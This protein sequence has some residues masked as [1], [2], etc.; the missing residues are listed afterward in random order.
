MSGE[1]SKV[2][3]M[4]GEKR[5]TILLVEDDVIIAMA[6]AQMLER[7]GYAVL[8]AYS[9]EEAVEAALASG[10]VDLI[11]MDI[12]LGRGMDGTEAAEIILRSRNVPVVFLSSHTE[13]SVVEKTEKITS[14]GYVVKNI[15]ETVLLASIK[16]AFRLHEAKQAELKKEKDLVESESLYRALVDSMPDIVMRFDAE[17]RHLFVSKNI[18]DLVAIPSVD[19]IGKTHREKGFPENLC[20]FWEASIR[21][22][23]SENKHFEQE[24][25]VPCAE[26]ERVLNLRLV[27]EIDSDGNVSSVLSIARDIT[28]YKK[29]ES[30]YH[31][32]FREAL[33]GFAL[34]EIVLDEIGNPCDYRFLSVNPAF[35]KITGLRSADIIGKTVLEVLPG[36]EKYWIEIY[37]RVALK[38]EQTIFENYSGELGKYFKVSAYQPSPGK[39]ACLFSDITAQKQSEA[40]IRKQDEYLRLIIES[41]PIGI[42]ILD[43]DEKCLFVNKKFTSISGYTIDDM[44]SSKEWWLKA[45]PDEPYRFSIR[46]KWESAISNVLST[47]EEMEPLECRVVCKDGREVQAEISFVPVGEL[48]A[49]T[50][51]KINER[52]LS[53]IALQESVEQALK[54]ERKRLRR[55]I[56][57]ADVIIV[58]INVDRTIAL[59]NRKG[60]ETLGRS[61]DELI[62]RNWFDAAVPAGIRKE[63]EEKFS[64]LESGLNGPVDRVENEI[65]RADGSTRTISWHNTVVRDDSGRIT[66]TLISGE[67]ITDILEKRRRMRTLLEMIDSAP[68][69]ITVHDF[70]GRF[71]YANRKTFEMHGWNEKEFMEL[72]LQKLDAPASQALI[73]ERTA[74]IE[75]NGEAVFESEHYRKDGTIFPLELFV[76]K[77]EWEGRPAMLSIATDIT[78]RKRWEE[79]LTAAL[80]EKQALLRELQH[81]IK[82]T[83]AMIV[84]L[85]NLESNRT[86]NPE[87]RE[88]LD[89]LRGRID[90][91]SNLYTLLFESGEPR[92]VRLDR[93]VSAI[94]E[95]IMKSYASSEVR[96]GL[97][98]R[99]DEIAVGAKFAS[100]LGLLLNE[101]LM[102][103]FKYAFKEADEGLVKIDLARR[104]DVLIIEVE[105]N[106]VGLPEGFDPEKSPGFGLRLA[107]LLTRQMDGAFEFESGAGT[108]FRVKLPLP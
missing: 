8:T 45:Y 73:E 40:A 50:F 82:N 33:E 101:L 58:A 21:D 76:K 94:G 59:I 99:A 102:N 37:G 36:T 13:P 15:G 39:F 93:Y 74:L 5:K 75:K 14:Y 72:T 7:H 68:S 64:I 47:G 3:L 30:D 81:R 63:L 100:S 9:G 86:E 87:A 26:G 22:V 6:E 66:G 78:E 98:V 65:V 16:M 25:K 85:T 79:E 31:L 83:L 19:F 42:I 62:G 107:V 38:G 29:L 106:G 24:T 12:D 71:L 56:D 61:E 20:D 43:H 46:G 105:D 104:D 88:A 54:T 90:S 34:H 53:K 96:I 4:N 55:Y 103:S 97:E 2:E 51:N 57:V 48:K 27:P 60:C 69:S 18:I 84:S 52:K 89:T 10:S 70:E 17:G 23:F 28:E 49:V 108:K 44:P 95:S 1:R 11:L 41:A 80:E 32:L 77:S 92:E 67:D 91:L 35:E